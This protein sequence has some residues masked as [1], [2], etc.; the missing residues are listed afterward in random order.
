MSPI[1]SRHDPESVAALADALQELQA[2][3]RSPSRH[4]ADFEQDARF[5]LDRLD[6]RI[7]RSYIR[8]ARQK[9]R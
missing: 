1:V 2:A 9:A 6:V 8:E 3:Q 5:I 7:Q 4:R